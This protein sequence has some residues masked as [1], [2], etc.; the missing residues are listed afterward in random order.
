MIRRR[1]IFLLVPVL[2]LSGV[3][4]GQQE[5]AAPGGAATQPAAQEQRK[6]SLAEVKIKESLA[7]A[8]DAA[9]YPRINAATVGE[10]IRLTINDKDLV[11]TSALPATDQAIVGTPGLGGL[12]RVT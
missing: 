5:L 12:T 2:A 3:V 6:E 4:H 10:V 1:P 7:A 9:Q 8:A 11:V